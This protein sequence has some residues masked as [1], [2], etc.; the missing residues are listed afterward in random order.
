MEYSDR[1][2]ALYSWTESK[3]RISDKIKSIYKA[4]ETP[5]S[6]YIMAHHIINEKRTACI[7]APG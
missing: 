3:V 6:E 4:N 7:P 2:F 1:K 5:M